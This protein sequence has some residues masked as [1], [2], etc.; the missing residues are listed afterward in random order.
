[1]QRDAV[2]IVISCGLCGNG[3]LFDGAGMI[4]PP[5]GTHQRN[6]RRGGL[7]GLNEKILA[8]TNGLAL[9]HAGNVVNAILIHL[10]AS[11]IDVILSACELD[12]LSIIE[13]DLATLKWSV[14]RDLEFCL[15]PSHGA[16][17]AAALL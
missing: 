4:V 5:A 1:M 16:Q 6:L 12:P 15:G 7:A 2:E 3:N 9:V 17:V 13:L 10:E 8:D 14:G 11:A